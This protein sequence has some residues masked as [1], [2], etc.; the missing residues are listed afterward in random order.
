MDKLELQRLLARK[1]VMLNLFKH[2]VKVIDDCKGFQLGE[3]V[4]KLKEAR[5]LFCVENF[6]DDTCVKFGFNDM[7]NAVT[8]EV[9]GVTAT[10]WVILYDGDEVD[11]DVTAMYLSTEIERLND[12]YDILT[13]ALKTY[14]KQEHKADW[15]KNVMRLG[16]VVG[17][18]ANV[19]FVYSYRPT[20]VMFYFSART[21]NPNRM[22]NFQITVDYDLGWGSLCKRLREYANDYDVD[23]ETYKELDTKGHGRNGAPYHIGD[24]LIEKE[25]IKD[26]LTELAKA[27]CKGVSVKELLDS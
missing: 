20:E 23:T 13:R 15:V 25:Q 26:E 27:V 2:Y 22:H 6:L 14:D 18:V 4:D 1:K 5:K 19:S 7:T 21:E 11:A 10:F 8:I 24:I 3:F 9:M 17:K 12:E 16:E